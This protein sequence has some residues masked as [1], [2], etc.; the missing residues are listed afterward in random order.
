MADMLQDQKGDYDDAVWDIIQTAV[1]GD[2][3]ITEAARRIAALPH[4]LTADEVRRVVAGYDAINTGR[5][6]AYVRASFVSDEAWLEAIAQR[7]NEVE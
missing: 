5:M 2:V 7:A 3:S 6:P 4:K 1:S